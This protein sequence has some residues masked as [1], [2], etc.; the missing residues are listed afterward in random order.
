MATQ[1]L[2]VRPFS[3]GFNAE[4]SESN[5]FQH[6]PVE[7]DVGGEAQAEFDAAVD[8]IRKAGVA[9]TV[10]DDTRDPVKPDAVFPN[11]W[12]SV[13]GSRAILYPMQAPNRRKERRV[14]V[15]RAVCGAGVTV[16]D[17][18]LRFEDSGQFLEGTGSMVLNR[19]RKVAYA[20]LS[21]RTHPTPL[22]A[23]HDLLGYDVVSFRTRH[24][25]HGTEVYHTNVM[26]SVGDS[27]AV[28]CLDVILP[29]D[30]ASVVSSLTASGVRDI[31]DIT[32]DQMDSFAGNVLQ[33]R[34]ERGGSAW[35]MSTTAAKAFTADQRARLCADGSDIVAVNIPTIETV[36]GGSARCMLAEVHCPQ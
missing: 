7:C 20:A 18:L 19:K 15:V 29:E 14:S 5:S 9:V 13:H 1:L 24:P 12:I 16:D 28:V 30:R 17:S 21:P 33:V 10:V 31:V 23:F 22:A 35:V 25:T 3:F 36:G 26:M 32:V 27:V 11:N 34:T 8:T 6:E 2:M 4:T